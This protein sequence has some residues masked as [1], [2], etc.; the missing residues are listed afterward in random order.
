MKG[1]ILLIGTLPPEL[2]SYNFGGVAQVVWLLA[3][4]LKTITQDVTIG[5]TGFYYGG[6]KEIEGVSIRGLRLKPQILISVLIIAIKNRKLFFARSAKDILR[7]TFALLLL[8]RITIQ[9][10]FECVCVHHVHNQVPLAVNLMELDIPVI[11]TIHSYTNIVMETSQ[12]KKNRAVALINEQLSCVDFVTHVS[13]NVRDQGKALGVSWNCP[14]EIIY[15]GIAFTEIL[16]QTRSEK[17]LCFVGSFEKQKGVYH[18]IKALEYLDNSDL[19]DIMLW[20][21]KGK[22]QREIEAAAANY[23]FETKIPGYLEHQMAIE[24]MAKSDLLIVPS[25]SESFGLVYI[26]SLYIGTPVIGFHGIINEFRTL[27]NL[28]QVYD[29]WM[30][31]YDASVEKPEA[32]AGKIKIAI[33][34]KKRSTYSQ[35]W[36]NIQTAIEEHFSWNKIALQY[37]KVCN[38]VAKNSRNQPLNEN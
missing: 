4:T 34:T 6:D 11:A 1:S 27:F 29:N 7:L 28:G 32:L 10:S 2:G 37:N 38:E 3:K 23:G 26:E 17:Q 22:L 15:N 24:Q 36:Q 33:N 31:P 35:E 5:V 9:G 8:K 30:I 19:I 18:L 25:I 21:G 12:R 14:D 16:K 13:S 20:L